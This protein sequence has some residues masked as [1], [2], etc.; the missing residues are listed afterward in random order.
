MPQDVTFEDWMWVSVV[1]ASSPSR[2]DLHN[3]S[4]RRFALKF[5]RSLLGHRSLKFF[6]EGVTRSERKY[7]LFKGGSTILRRLGKPTIPFWK[8]FQL[9]GRHLLY[10]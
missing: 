4:S 1:R 5:W 3:M 10:Y 2:H 7:E 6:L 9:G 8:A